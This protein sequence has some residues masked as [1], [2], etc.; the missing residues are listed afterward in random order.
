MKNKFIYFAVI[1]ALGFA[2]CEPE[3]DKEV[4]NESYS[5]GEANFTSYVAIGNSLD[6]KSVV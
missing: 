4:N 2:S 6:R 3:F 5:A 1:A